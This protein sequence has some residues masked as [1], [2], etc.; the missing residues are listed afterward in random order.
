M[1]V[2]VIGGNGFV[3]WHFVQA[4]LERGHDVSVVGR[5]AQPQRPLP[6][7]VR[8]L[9]GSLAD[10][11]FLR[12]A[13]IG[14][15]AV[16]HLASTTVPSTGDKN[17]PNDV[18]QNLLGTL[19]LLEEMRDS[20]TSR[21]LFLSSGGTV[22]GPPQII[23]VPESHPLAPTCSYGIV[24]AA[25]EMYL[26]LY[27]RNAGLRP[28]VIRA[29]NPYGPLQG[30]IGVQGIIG[31]FLRRLADGQ[32]IE[33]W[34]DGSVVRDFIY[35]KDLARLCVTALESDRV[36]TYNGGSGTGTSIREIADVV[37][38]V[39]GLHANIVHW[40]ARGVDVPISVLDASL[41]F[42]ALGWKAATS[43]VDGIAATWEDQRLPPSSR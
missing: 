2:L 18:S 28:I 29:S 20:G 21:L 32:P 25:I 17:P 30:N 15:D 39:S 27:M 6:V 31:T 36:G 38:K 35:V 8:Y 34:G 43:L 22:Y 16:A 3:G 37:Q 7:S 12:K 24:K 5:S 26:G 42:E 41:A 4:L 10:R 23:P 19:G 1:K 14:M 11:A 33:I 9:S 13:L 40:P